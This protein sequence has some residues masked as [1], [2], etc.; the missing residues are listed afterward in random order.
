MIIENNTPTPTIRLR[1]LKNH[2]PSRCFEKSLPRSMYYLL[3]DILFISTCYF[4]YPYFSSSWIGLFAYWNIYGFFMWCLF[5]I[6]HD[7]GHNA[8]SKYPVINAICGHLCHTP[9]LVPYFPWAYSH[10][11]HHQFHNHVTKDHSH[12]WLT[13]EI[14][15]SHFL[16]K[17]YLTSFLAPLTGFYIYLYPG[18]ND[19]S[20]INPMS[21]LF[22]DSKKEQIKCGISTFSILCF[23][24][25]LYC[26]FDSWPQFMLA[27]GGCLM[28]FSFWLFMVT[29]LHHHHEDIVIFDDS[30]WNFISGALQTIDR[31]YGFGLDKLNHNATD[32]HVVHHL[33]F[34][35]IP[36]YHLKEA[37]NAIRPLLGKNYKFHRHKFFLKD[38][39]ILF[40]KV[41]F[42]KWILHKRNEK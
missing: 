30:N 29:Y 8:F 19:G 16:R 24:G 10:R 3:R 23:V 39:W 1:D 12:P 41:H 18:Q 34:S 2:I 14:V 35:L 11:K 7:C 22:Q 32:G 4:T 5:V 31:S 38:F 40:S 9:L 27:Y 42:T 25:L 37:T 21:K 13:E 6:G 33:F 20:H 28:V 15:Q 26:I 36:H 17:T